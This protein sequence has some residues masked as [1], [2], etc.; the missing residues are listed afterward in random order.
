[1]TEQE[2]TELGMTE[3]RRRLDAGEIADPE[4]RRLAA[5]WLLHEAARREVADNEIAKVQ[6]AKSMSGA[7][8]IVLVGIVIGAVLFKDSEFLGSLAVIAALYIGLKV[9][10]SMR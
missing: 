8:A 9:S 3:L 5:Q 10:G 6:E 1:M 7:Y 2:M 4:A